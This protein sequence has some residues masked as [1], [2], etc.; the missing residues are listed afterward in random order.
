M[1]FGSFFRS[2]LP[3]IGTAVGGYFGGPPGAALGGSVG[4]ALAGGPSSTGGITGLAQGQGREQGI[5]ARGYYDEA[6]PG[7]NPWERLGAGNPMSAMASSAINAKSQQRNVDATNRN[8]MN[9]AAAQMRQQQATANTQAQAHVTGAKIAGR[10]SAYNTGA[11]MAPGD[12]ARGMDAVAE[13]TG[14]FARGGPTA[15]RMGA[16]A[17]VS[18]AE[19]ARARLLIEAEKMLTERGKAFGSPEI[20]AL[21]S[22]A[23]QTFGFGMKSTKEWEAHLNKG[24]WKVYMAAGVAAHTIK[25]GADAVGKVLGARVRGVPASGA[26][27]RFPAKTSV[28]GAPAR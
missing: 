22:R 11:N 16:G 2:V 3:A 25:Q 12:T 5:E 13:G 6:F 8:Q 27:N 14:G 15:Q 18:Q 7:T 26:G 4:T 17:A 24:W 1:G 9:I 19:S 21:A 23:A 20:A 28:R 10:A